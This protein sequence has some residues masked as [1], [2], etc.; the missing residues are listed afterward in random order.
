MQIVNVGDGYGLATNVSAQC[1]GESS[2]MLGR[3]DSATGEWELRR[4]RQMWKEYVH[5]FHW[6]VPFVN[7]F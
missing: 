6:P 2:F 7:F 5:I 3:F 4:T 1:P